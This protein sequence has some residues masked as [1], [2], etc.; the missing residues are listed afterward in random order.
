[1]RQL[2]PD[3]TSTTLDRATLRAVQTPQAFDAMALIKAYH[4]PYQPHFT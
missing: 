1:M 3:G 2:C 4:T